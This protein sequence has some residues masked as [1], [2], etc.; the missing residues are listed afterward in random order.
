MQ[1]KHIMDCPQMTAGDGS[2]LREILSPLRDEMPIRYSLAHAVV[3]PGSS[4]R[5]HRL[6]SSEVYYVISGKGR[7]H[8]ANEKRTVAAG[9]VVHIPPGA[10]QWIENIGEEDLTFLCIVDPPWRPE[11]DEPV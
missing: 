6:K 7:M 8:V 10:V 9:H 1:V 2:L 5:P 11:D 3:K 4:T